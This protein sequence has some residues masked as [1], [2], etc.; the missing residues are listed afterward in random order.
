M[1]L[2]SRAFS[3]YILFRHDGTEFSMRFVCTVNVNVSS[4]MS[5]FLVILQHLK[6]EFEPLSMLKKS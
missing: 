2:S 3:L 5:T 6:I 1:A 4:A